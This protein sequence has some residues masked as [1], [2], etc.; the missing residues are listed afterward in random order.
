MRG[1]RF[2]WRAI[3]PGLPWLAALTLV[4][5]AIILWVTGFDQQTSYFLIVLAAAASL[6]QL[7]TQRGQSEAQR[8]ELEQHGRDLRRLA[9]IAQAQAAARPAPTLNAVDP[10]TSEAGDHITRQRPPLPVIQQAAITEKQ[11][12]TLR[13]VPENVVGE[14]AL[15]PMIIA[16]RKMQSVNE[17]EYQ[18]QLGR[19]ERDLT[20]WLV[21]VEAALARQHEIVR[22]PLR[23]ENSG[24]ASLER[25]V[26][27]ISL[28]AGVTATDLPTMPDGPP[29]PPKRLSNI[30]GLSRTVDALMRARPGLDWSGTTV[31]SRILEGPDASDDLRTVR[32]TLSELLHTHSIDAAGDDALWLHVPSDDDYELGW[33]IHAPALTVPVP[34]SIH[35]TVETDQ[36]EPHQFT[37]LEDLTA[38]FWPQEGE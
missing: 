22:V 15:D 17:A 9:D 21:E 10:R 16:I 26:I 24:G 1:P 32:Y 23:I 33:Q 29:P 11:M 37:D 30:G 19:Y 31:G 14:G 5:I 3:R 18:K 36:S 20:A 28:P 38:V 7:L 27:E 25:A 35:L 2:F 4:L 34:G 8:S 12:E 13:P 6:L